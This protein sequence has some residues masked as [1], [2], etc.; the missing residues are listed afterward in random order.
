MSPSVEKTSL[1]GYHVNA[2]SSGH[3][4]GLRTLDAVRTDIARHI[5]AVDHALDRALRK[6]TH[7][8]ALI[9]TRTRAAARA[10]AHLRAI[11]RALDRIYDLEGIPSRNLPVDLMS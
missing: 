9:G 6:R 5:T 3:S 4:V 10:L 2:A 11:N 1:R 7:S 8:I